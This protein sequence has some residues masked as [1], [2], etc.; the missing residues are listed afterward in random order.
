MRYNNKKFLSFLKKCLMFSGITL[1]LSMSAAIFFQRFDI[2][3][4]LSFLL[5]ALLVLD[6]ILNFSFVRIQQENNRLIIRFYSLFT[7]ERNYESIE[8]PVASL[9][10]IKVKK[11][12]FGLKWDL[13]LTVKLKQ[14]M[15]SYPA[16][17][18]SAIPFRDRKILLEQFNN[19]IKREEN[20]R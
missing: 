11:Y 19:L 3:L 18:L 17:C 10:Y 8:F 6:R 20:Y 14:G 16:I 5:I 1:L 12:L 15:A 9:R 7:V 2:V 4:I 13:Y